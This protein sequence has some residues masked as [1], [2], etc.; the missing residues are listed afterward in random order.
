MT[1]CE[2]VLH[3]YFS[4]F[5]PRICTSLH[6][7]PTEEKKKHVA[8]IRTICTVLQHAIKPGF[9]TNLRSPKSYITQF[10]VLSL[11]SGLQRAGRLSHSYWLHVNQLG[12]HHNA[13][14]KRGA[15]KMAA[16]RKRLRL[17]AA[18]SLFWKMTVA[19]RAKKLYFKWR[20]FHWEFSKS[21]FYS[22]GALRVSVN[23]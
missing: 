16:T 12:L 22:Q 7:T 5:C 17:R 9:L 3:M 14:M 4:M 23:K 20:D 11:L 21:D 18:L 1:V 6:F 15:S 10:S 8:Q 13:T 19:S 2:L